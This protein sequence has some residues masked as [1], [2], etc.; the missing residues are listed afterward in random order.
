MSSLV[1]RAKVQWPGERAFAF[2]V[3]D[4]P[5][6]QT[7][8]GL[9]L[10]YDFL[11]NA[12][13]RTTLGVWPCRPPRP[14]NSY[15]VTCA[16]LNYRS[17][18]QC[19]GRAGFEVGYHHTT[20]HSSFRSEIANGLD[21]FG[22]FFGSAPITMANHYNAEAIYWGHNRLGG[23]RRILYRAANLARRG[24]PFSGHVDSSKYFWGDFCQ[25]RVR[26]CRNFTYHDINTL[27][28]CPWMPYH[29]VERPFVNY[30]FASSYGATIRSFLTLLSEE[31]QDRL[32]A[33]GGA[34][35]VYA[36]FGMGFV[37]DG[38]L[39]ARFRFLMNRLKEKKGWFV[40]VRTLLD[41][42]LSLRPDPA[43]TSEQR[44]L[45]EWKWLWARRARPSASSD[46][47]EGWEP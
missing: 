28:A 11:G 4:D 1:E 3:F 40:P 30:W 9:R 7:V 33:E 22:E 37:N 8:E 26:Y 10:V 29:D 46:M 45:M 13:L 24:T 31:N 42:L 43:I 19:L 27:R 44:R 35:I 6:A 14:R 18:A 17:Y 21:T 16:N 32:E 15:G 20:P 2:T 47:P 41:Y 36:H 25:Q 39:D 12:G 5:D 38:G 23:T 34:C